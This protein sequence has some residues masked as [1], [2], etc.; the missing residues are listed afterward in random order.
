[1][2]APVRVDEVDDPPVPQPV[3]EVA[4]RTAH[5]ERQAAGEQALARRAQAPH[6]HD[7]RH[8][9][10]ECQHHEQPALPAGGV[11]EEAEGRAGVVGED[12]V[13]HRQHVHPLEEVEVVHDPG[14]D[15]LVEHDDEQRRAAASASRS[16]RRGR[17]AGSPAPR[18]DPAHSYECPLLTRALDVAD[19]TR[20]SCGWRA[21][22]PT[23]ARCCQQRT[24]LGSSVA[25]AAIQT[26]PRAGAHRRHRRPRRRRR[27]RCTLRL[28]GDEAG[29]AAPLPAPRSAGTRAGVQ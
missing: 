9:H 4:E 18:R 23:S 21:S 28:G 6:P 1:M 10:R 16:G 8:A 11:G 27:T 20:H 24:H 15:Q 2:L 14:L 19:A 12:D 26:P 5:D 7:Q 17:T 3:D 22:A 29:S 13:Q 25:A